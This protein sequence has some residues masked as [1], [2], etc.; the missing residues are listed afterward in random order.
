M[1]LV[2][3]RNELF[4]KY[5]E[6]NE[7]FLGDIFDTIRPNFELVDRLNQDWTQLADYFS[8]N[9]R[10]KFYFLCFSIFIKN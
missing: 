9:R 10:W 2:I 8:I 3:Q 4:W 5:I 6:R 1:D 7:V